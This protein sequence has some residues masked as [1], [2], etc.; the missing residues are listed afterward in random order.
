MSDAQAVPL[1]TEDGYAAFELASTE[2]HE[3]VDGKVRAMTGAS[4]QHNTVAGNLSMLLRGMAKQTGCRVTI[5]GVRL[6]VNS[7]RH[8]YP[9][10]MATCE[11]R[12]H[13]S[14][15]PSLP[16]RRDRITNDAS[17]DRGESAWPT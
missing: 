14:S 3:Y 15:C 6:K 9:D 5:E 7:K 8:Y 17:I 16:D 13:P 4:I 2:R 1:L 12:R 11:E 10:V